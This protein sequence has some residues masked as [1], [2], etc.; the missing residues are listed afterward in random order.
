MLLLNKKVRAVIFALISIAALFGR[1]VSGADVLPVEVLMQES[2]D[3]RSK[4]LNF[5]ALGSDY[6]TTEPEKAK[7]YAREGFR[8]ASETHD[9]V[10]KARLARLLGSTFTMT[11]LYD[12]AEI[13]LKL[14]EH[15]AGKSDANELFGVI[16]LSFGTLLTRQKR[17]DE[18]MRRLLAARS[19][20]EKNED[21]ENL[22]RT[23]ANIAGLFMY[24][25]N[26]SQAEKYYLE[27]RDLSA[28]LHN[29]S[30]L[31]QAYSGLVKINLEKQNHKAA[32]DYGL[33]SVKEFHL[34]KE[35]AYE[36][37]AYKELAGIY[38][39]LN[40]IQNAL[41]A[42]YQSLTLAHETGITRYI[43]NAMGILADISYR[44]GN[45]RKSI[46]FAFGSL[47][48]DSSDTETK[49]R[50]LV[51]LTKSYISLG[52]PEFAIQYFERYQKEID[53][54]VD[55]KYRRSISEMEVRY[56][57]H[58]KELSI[59][60][61]QARKRLITQSAVS[62]VI[63]LMLV[64]ITFIFREKNIRTKK[65]LTEQRVVQL[66]Q[67]RQLIATQALLAGEENERQRLAGD[68]HDGLGG[69]LTGVK[70]KLSPM[71]EN[72]MITGEY[73]IQFG[74]A[75]DLLD[76]SIA[77]MRRV[78]HN[79]MPET[80]MHYGLRTALRD[81]TA[82]VKPEGKPEI[83]LSTFG[84][85]LRYSREI[86]IT[87]YRIAQELVNNSLKHAR[88][89]RIDVQLF[90]ENGRIC[91]QVIDNGIGFDAEEKKT[92]NRGNGLQ[93]IRDRITAF[94]GRF[95]IFSE[96]GKGTESTLEFLIP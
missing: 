35:K 76:K 23:L 54:Q 51:V 4:A 47:K 43:A 72:S 36:S 92:Y 32:L 9:E 63:I 42:G 79:L 77:E 52:K 55:E 91:V 2:A 20:F 48:T 71:K 19:Y 18:A 53:I 6:L 41:D 37:V 86:E 61:L 10:L 68:L 60:K 82:Q 39:E 59:Q 56:E 87:V 75:L 40:Q 31:G 30:G 65:K 64:V 46:E 26:Y 14:A 38:L 44:E 88:A 73:L 85:E 62:V 49:T 57:T 7:H 17:S 24:Q 33:A 8:I 94:N 11:G 15:L 81:Y 66:E 34:S 80:L 28:L 74:Q 13:Y 67:E 12:S 21:R 78:A 22:R 1:M 5:E 29:H 84:D 83:C 93:S 50:L 69:L 27:A 45:F 3:L 58:K 95:E 16:N 25:H 90:T 70:L 89:T 96:A